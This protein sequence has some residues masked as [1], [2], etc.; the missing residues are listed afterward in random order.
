MLPT[1]LFTP[2]DEIIRRPRCG[3]WV[4]GSE[5]EV[6]GASSADGRVIKIGNMF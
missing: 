1:K 2:R 5:G 3:L 6:N 4:V